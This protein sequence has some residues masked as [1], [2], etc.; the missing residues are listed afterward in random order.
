LC[1]PILFAA[2][3]SLFDTLDGSLMTAAYGW[4]RDKPVHRIYYNLVVTSL[5]VVVA[6]VIGTIEILG[7]LGERFN[8]RGTIWNWATS[9]DLSRV[10]FVIVGLFVAIWMAAVLIWK[11]RRFETR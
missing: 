6:L 7:L 2:G 3:M 8:L 11:Y 5:S 1:L 10:G 4:A 9:I